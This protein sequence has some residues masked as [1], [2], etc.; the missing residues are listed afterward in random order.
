MSGDG[1][2]EPV[3]LSLRTTTRLRAAPDADGE[4]EDEVLEAE[5]SRRTSLTTK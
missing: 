5:F 2:D 3:M 4:P 1:E